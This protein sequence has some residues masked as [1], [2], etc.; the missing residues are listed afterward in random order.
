MKKI[1]LIITALIY[2]F[3][4]ICSTAAAKT[5]TIGVVDINKILANYTVAQEVTANLKVQENELKKFVEKSKKRI[6]NAKT[7]IERNNLKEKLSAQFNIKRNAYAK[8]QSEKWQKIENNVLAKIKKVAKDKKIDII[9]N[10]QSVII[11]GEDI[12]GKV[13]D[14][15]NKEAKKSK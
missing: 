5:E 9:L 2:S 10:K 15:L 6:K 8:D 7:P 11:G 1:T 4:F 3:I 12:T 13:I 14:G